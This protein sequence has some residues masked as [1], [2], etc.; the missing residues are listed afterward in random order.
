MNLN[1]PLYDSQIEKLGYR[2]IPYSQ[3]KAK[4]LE[5]FVA[6]CPFVILY[7]SSPKSGHYCCVFIN[8][9]GL[10]FLDPYGKINN[11]WLMAD[12][13]LNWPNMKRFSGSSKILKFM[14]EYKKRGGNVYGN[15]VK[16]QR[17]MNGVSTCGWHCLMRLIFSDLSESEYLDLMKRLKKR[18]KTKDF[19]ELVVKL[20][21]EY[22]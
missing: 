12:Q 16:Y 9:H 4:T 22:I 20:L 7:Q 5:Q 2:V 3:L 13:Q 17:Y 18:F 10:N 14:D 8:E 21:Q 15:D 11:K 6:L 19:D 1:Q